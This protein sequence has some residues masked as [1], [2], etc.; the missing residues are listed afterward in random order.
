MF[1]Y[2]INYVEIKIKSTNFSVLIHMG[3]LGTSLFGQ[4]VG[5]NNPNPNT[6]LDVIGTTTVE[7]SSSS[8]N[9]QIELRGIGDGFSR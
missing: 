6:A 7:R 9:P 8:S 3:L 1:Y 4:N 2:E 5:V